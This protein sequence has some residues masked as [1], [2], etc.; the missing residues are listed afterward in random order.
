MSD[1]GRRTPVGSMFLPSVGDWSYAYTV[2]EGSNPLDPTWRLYL[3]IGEAP[4]PVTEWD[5][6]IAEDGLSASIRVESTDVQLVAK[7]TRFWLMLQTDDNEPGVE[8]L[9]GKVVK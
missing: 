1:I 8:L 4:S 2:A 6:T 3:A 9:T 7:N 5:F